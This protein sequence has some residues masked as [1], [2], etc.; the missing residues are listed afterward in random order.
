VQRDPAPSRHQAKK[1]RKRFWLQVM[2][3][4]I[5]LAMLLPVVAFLFT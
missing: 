5:V 1:D 3:G 2:C 4:I